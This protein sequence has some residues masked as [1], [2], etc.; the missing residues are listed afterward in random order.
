MVEP[1]GLPKEYIALPLL[2]MNTIFL[3]NNKG[4]NAK[5]RRKQHGESRLCVTFSFVSI[6]KIKLHNCLLIEF[7]FS[8]K[9]VMLN[10]IRVMKKKKQINKAFMVTLIP[11]NLKNKNIQNKMATT[12]PQ[13]SKNKK[14]KGGGVSK[15]CWNDIW[16]TS[17]LVACWKSPRKGHQHCHWDAGLSIF[18]SLLMC[19][20]TE[21]FS[22]DAPAG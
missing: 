9:I 17:I 18:G 6:V 4:M 13:N 14:A 16:K 21:N 15:S 12:I 11:K 1:A 10:K 5:K 8:F 7:I 22:L 19:R 3:W 2:Y 20:C